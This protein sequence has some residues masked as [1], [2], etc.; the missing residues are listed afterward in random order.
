MDADVF[1]EVMQNDRQSLVNQFQRSFEKIRIAEEY[2]SAKCIFIK[3]NLTY[4]RYK[5]GVTTR[6][7]FV[8]CLVEA[9]NTFPNKR[10]I[11]IGEGEGGY[12]SFSMTK[13][14]ELM[15]FFELEKKY[16]NV[17]VINLSELKTRTVPIE[18]KFGQYEIS[19][20]DCFPS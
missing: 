20:P 4:P 13:T 2:Q 16:K 12:N 14:L 9:L 6:V 8:D 11:Y 18:T 5:P 19:L 10:K 3:P 1:V 15:G 7:L 17:K